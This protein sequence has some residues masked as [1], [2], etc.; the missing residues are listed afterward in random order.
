MKYTRE[1]YEHAKSVAKLKNEVIADTFGKWKFQEQYKQSRRGRQGP[2][3]PKEATWN[4]LFNT[5]SVSYW[6]VIDKVDF[7]CIPYEQ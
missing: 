1:D 6:N 7:I 5:A 3:T 2:T 4:Y